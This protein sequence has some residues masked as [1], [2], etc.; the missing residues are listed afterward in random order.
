MGFDSG[1][2][3]RFASERIKGPD[4]LV[5]DKQEV[6][7]ALALPVGTQA[8]LL[9]KLSTIHLLCRIQDVEKWG[10]E[11]VGQWLDGLGL[12][13]H[14][15]SFASNDITGKWLLRLSLKDLEELGV[16]SLGRRR[17]L[18]DAIEEL[19]RNIQLTK[20]VDSQANTQTDTQQP[21]R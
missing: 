15:E 20:E 14:R 4:L 2:A 16:T 6:R 11:E 13:Q 18:W 17:E 21:P 3:S 12:S 19:N 7:E 5:L 9:T 10:V 1:V 8:R